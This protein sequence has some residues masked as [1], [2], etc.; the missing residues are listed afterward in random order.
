VNELIEGNGIPEAVVGFLDRGDLG[1]IVRAEPLEGGC[2]SLTRRLTTS[3]GRTFV[4]KQD[5]DPP[6]GM[7]V[8]EADGLTALAVP[9]APRVPRV[10]SVAEDHILVEDLG[11]GNVPQDGY[12]REFG[13]AVARLHGNT[14]AKYGFARPSYLG[15]LPVTYAWCDDPHEFFV[16]HSMLRFLDVPRCFEVLT[17]EERKAVERMAKRLPDLVPAQ[18]PS[19]VHGDLWFTNM[20]VGPNG[21]PAAIDPSAH[22]GLPEAELVLPRLWGNV[23]D[24]F[25][26]AYRELHPLEPGWEERLKLLSVGEFLGNVAHFGERGSCLKP[27]R[28]LLA[29]FAA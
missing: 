5:A 6:P 22:Y 8:A 20:L 2:Q 12:W 16:R 3:T 18:G 25:Y 15:R 28:E 23:P 19:L 27:L 11:T 29:K 24:E 7:Y 4:L 10:F 14:N 17:A 26:D 9:G 21:E 13:R 1:D